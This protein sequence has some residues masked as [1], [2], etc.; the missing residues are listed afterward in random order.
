M[1]CII[2]Q[3]L[4]LVVND[5]LTPTHCLLFQYNAT[6]VKYV[7]GVE[8]ISGSKSITCGDIITGTTVGEAPGSFPTCGTSNSNA[9]AVYFKLEGASGNT[10][11]NLCNSNYD[12]KVSVFRDVRECG[13]ILVNE[14]VGGNDDACG[15]D[16]IGSSFT[17]PDANPNDVYYV[18]VHGYLADRYPDSGNY[19]L[20]VNCGT[21]LPDTMDASPEMAQMMKER[22]EMMHEM[23]T[24][25]CEESERV[26][27]ASAGK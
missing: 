23:Q 12:T 19:K 25:D 15:D 21:A 22:E 20:A 8:T 16:G 9:P 6:K 26:C 27:P 17:I 14:R 7:T 11:I 10:E 4:Y 1:L 18:I 2:G 13:G 3:Y 24:E 5:Y